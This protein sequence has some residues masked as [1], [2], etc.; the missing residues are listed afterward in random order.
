MA[1]PTLARTRQTGAQS[2][3]DKTAAEGAPSRELLQVLEYAPTLLAVPAVGFG[4]AGL[5]G[6]GPAFFRRH[7]VVSALLACGGMVTLFKSQFDRFLLEQPHYEVEG[8][9]NGL[10]LRRYAP[11]R[12]A[13]TR[14]EVS[15]FDEARKQAFQRLAAY[16]F[17]DNT[18][19]E[20][21]AMST[22]VSVAPHGS[23]H[24]S[25]PHG[26]HLPMTTPVTLGHS[27]GGYV[28]RFQLPK[29]RTLSSLP[30]PHDSRVRLRQ[31]PAE[32]VAVLRFS[33]SYSGEHIAAK[34]RELL[35]R[36]K[37][38]GF[39]ATGEPVFA[40][41]DSPVALPFLRRVEVWVPI[42]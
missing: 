28:M 32:R 4:V 31:V 29:D 16:I 2:A 7:P 33:G 39:S 23:D 18:A 15:S 12:V 36:V 14:V 3:L 21:L 26:E 17:G 38:A 22:P 41:Y 13:E 8:E 42:A 6:S 19:R 30:R 25:E 35:E 34:E 11:R 1:N 40:G 37:A 27:K 9:V 20:K 5:L 10:E 24:G